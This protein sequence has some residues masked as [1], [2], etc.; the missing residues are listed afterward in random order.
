M[1]ACYI[2]QSFIDAGPDFV[3]EQSAG[4]SSTQESWLLLSAPFQ[5][6]SFEVDSTVSIYTDVPL[7]GP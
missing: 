6:D 7:G 3:R 2:L 1:V 5:L 4:I